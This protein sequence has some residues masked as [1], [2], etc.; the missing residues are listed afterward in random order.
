MW[1]AKIAAVVIVVLL[2]VTVGTSVVRTYNKAVARAELLAKENKALV[3]AVR[4][5]E[6]ALSRERGVRART[7]A[8]LNARQAA[9]EV[10]HDVEIRKIEVIR[11]VQAECLD[12]R[13]PDDIIASMQ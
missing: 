1:Q 4:A 5:N 6:E 12:T 3:V 13:M 9:V 2:T 11:K 7:E 8:L 10:I